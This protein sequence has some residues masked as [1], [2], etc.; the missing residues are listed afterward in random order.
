MGTQDKR[1]DSGLDKVVPDPEKRGS[2]TYPGNAGHEVGKPEWDAK[3]P[4]THILNTDSQCNQ[5]VSFSGGMKSENP[6]ETHKDTPTHKGFFFFLSPVY[7][8]K[9][10]LYM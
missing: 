4:W 1:R 5:P 7:T 9:C 8:C 6:D 10:E 2:G 3:A